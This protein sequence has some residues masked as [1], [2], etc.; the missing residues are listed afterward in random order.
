[1]THEAVTPFAAPRSMVWKRR[2]AWTVA[3]F[4]ILLIG[5]AIVTPAKAE[6]T[7]VTAVSA[8][9]AMG[10]KQPGQLG[11]FLIGI[12]GLIIGRQS[13]IALSKRRSHL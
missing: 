6:T 4:I 2:L 12:I 9:K 13:G 10:I 7:V 3:A 5:F 1:M 11:M 8:M